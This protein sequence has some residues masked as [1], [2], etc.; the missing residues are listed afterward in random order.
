MV[1]RRSQASNAAASS[2]ATRKVS[3]KNTVLDVSSVTHAIEGPRLLTGHVHQSLSIVPKYDGQTEG[4][5]RYSDLL[6][7]YIRKTHPGSDIS[8][9]ENLDPMVN[10]LLYD[11]LAHGLDHHSYNLIRHLKYDGLKAFRYIDESILGDQNARRNECHILFASTCLEANDDIQTYCAK[12]FKLRQDFAAHNLIP[13]GPEGLKNWCDSLIAVQI[14]KFPRK[15]KPFADR[16]RDESRNYGWP[17]LDSFTKRLIEEARYLGS[18]TGTS[19]PQGSSTNST[20]LAVTARPNTSQHTRD[21]RHPQP[22]PPRAATTLQQS[23]GRRVHQPRNSR[24]LNRPRRGRGPRHTRGRG[25]GR[26]SSNNNQRH[27][28]GRPITCKNCLSRD[29]THDEHNCYSSKWCNICNNAS[30]NT[31]ICRFAKQ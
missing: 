23:E 15:F 10:E 6:H 27:P 9:S 12:L 21:H 29:N 4:W 30:H 18:N 24:S 20:V 16:L 19:Q 22:P 28:K 31:D 13:N 2:S 26:G 8:T 17:S 7:G 5:P 25:R 1:G 11:C 14:A 3:S